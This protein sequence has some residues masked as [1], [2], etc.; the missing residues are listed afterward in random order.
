[1]QKRDRPADPKTRTADESSRCRLPVRWKTNHVLFYSR[2]PV[3]FRA[4]VRDLAAATGPESNCGRSACAMK[5][6]ATMAMASAADA[7]AAIHSSANSRRFDRP[8]SRAG[9]V[10][11][12][13]KSPAT[14][15]ACSVASG[16]RSTA[17]SNQTA[18]PPVG[19][20]VIPSTA[21]HYPA[22]RLFRDEAVCQERKQLRFAPKPM[23]FSKSKN[24]SNKGAQHPAAAW[25]R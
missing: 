13:S 24:C 6:A 19:A 14:A 8:R 3:D 12:S 22:H 23:R 20:V 25:R 15:A 16:M 18:L 9:S 4:L 7:S 1:L 11:Q 2:P 10:P 17:M 21:R 5:P